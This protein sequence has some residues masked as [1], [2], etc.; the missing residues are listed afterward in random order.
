MNTPMP[1]ISLH[2]WTNL[3]FVL[4]IKIYFL[5]L[6]T[7]AIMYFYI[8]G[9][10]DGAHSTGGCDS[11][12]RAAKRRYPTSK[13][14]GRSWKDPMPEGRRPRGV[15]PCRGKGQWTRMPGWDSAGAAE[16]SYPTFKIRGSSRKCQATTAQEQLRGT[17]PHPRSGAAA[18]RSN[19][20]SKE[21]WFHGCRRT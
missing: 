4:K 6:V 2:V 7:R 16:R 14:R 8:R 13:V 9:G 21:Q 15:T 20:T 12:Q 5:E 17:T 18:E 3:G 11:K 1:N 10:C 19:P